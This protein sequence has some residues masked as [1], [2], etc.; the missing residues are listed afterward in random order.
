MEVTIVSNIIS[1]KSL[2]N[3]DRDIIMSNRLTDTFLNVLIIAGSRIAKTED[4]KRLIVWLAEKDQSAVG[5]GT[6]GFDIREM[7]WNVETFEKD[8]AFMLKTIRHALNK[9]HWEKLGYE[10][11]E[12]YVFPSLEQFAELIGEFEAD[13]IRPK[14]R[15]EWL[16]AAEED[17]PINNGFPVCPEHKAL[18]SIYGC[19]I[20]RN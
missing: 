13:D 8:K 4:Q 9:K 19:Q 7:P 3:P 15:T 2:H 11:N 6:V 20:C 18:L 5:E 10:P 12:K 16:E 17:D 14:E 1:C